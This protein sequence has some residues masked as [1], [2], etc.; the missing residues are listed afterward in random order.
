ML[1]ELLASRIG[2][3]PCEWCRQQ[4]AE[5]PSLSWRKLARLL[6]EQADWSVSHVSLIAW[7]G[8]GQAAS[9]TPST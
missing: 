2:M 4:R 8:D 7:C 5:D 9:G 1:R 3:D 6:S